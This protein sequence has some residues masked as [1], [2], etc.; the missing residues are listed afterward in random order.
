VTGLAQ[1]PTLDA[2]TGR[3]FHSAMTETGVFECSESMLNK[4]WQNIRWTQRDNMHGIPTDCPQRDERLG[5]MGDIQ[6]FAG[7]GI[8]NMDMAAF[9][10]K[11]MRD[12][13]DAQADDGRFADFSPHP[14]GR[15][16]R[17]TGVPGWGDAGIVVP[18]RMWQNYG[19]KRVL[20]ESFESSKRWVEFIRGNNPIYSGGQS[21][22]MI[23]AT[24]SIQIR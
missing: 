11:W 5:W 4:L 3:V 19:D 10:T 9:F 17:F 24:G 7:T 21:A 12:V 20:S 22:A 23:M 16:E 14:F 1:R 15:N 13:R 2:I 6:I 18:W 8:F